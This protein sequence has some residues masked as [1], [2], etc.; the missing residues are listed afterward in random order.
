MGRV[1][2][3]AVNCEVAS[4][5]NDIVCTADD[6]SREGMWGFARGDW[7]SSGCLLV[8]SAVHAQLAPVGA[9]AGVL[10][11]DLDGSTDIWDHRWL[12]GT[13]EPLAADLSSA[14]AGSDLLPA[15]ADAD[16]RIGRIT[17]LSGYR[18]NLGA[19]AT[20]AQGENTRGLLGLALGLTRKLTVFGRLPLVRVQVET[21][22]ALDP[23]GAD[24]GTNPGPAEQVTFFQQLDASLSAL[25][26]LHRGLATSTATPRSRRAPRPRSR[27]DR[28]PRRLVRPA[29]RSL[30]AA[31]FV[32]IA[33]STAGAAVAAPERWPSD[34]ARGGLRRLRL[35]R[36]SRPRHRSPRQ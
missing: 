17:G 22:F 20:D 21:H 27:R 23:A 33:T 7:R 31:S 11:V 25:G 12:D 8:P 15:L 34:F 18:L 4:L 6:F 30:T 1:A 13:R 5:A 9:P 16:A 19:L 28:A 24:A 3:V 2:K 32:P 35:H 29:R 26:G 14:A 10:R 36:R